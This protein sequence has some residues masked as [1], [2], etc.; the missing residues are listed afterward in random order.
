[1]R[2]V[3][4][5]FADANAL[6]NSFIIGDDDDD[7]DDVIN[8]NEDTVMQIDGDK[9]SAKAAATAAATTAAAAT[10]AATTAA[11]AAAVKRGK[12]GLALPDEDVA[13]G[14]RVNDVVAAYEALLDLPNMANVMENA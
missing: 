1:V 6:E 14:L 3:G 12:A 5:V 11:A 7:A 8:V 13:C 9:C 4:A 2:R 10:A